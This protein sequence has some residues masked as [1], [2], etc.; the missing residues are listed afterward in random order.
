MAFDKEQYWKNRKKGLRGQGPVY[1]EHHLGRDWRL[2]N[3]LPHPT[4]T[5]K[6]P[7]RY[8]L[9][10]NTKR[11]RLFARREAENAEQHS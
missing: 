2:T 10:K 11:A 9:R 7:G 6:K 5:E 8:A 4:K 3:W 1:R